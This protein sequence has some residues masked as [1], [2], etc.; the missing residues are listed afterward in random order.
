MGAELLDPI[1]H[2]GL[3]H[4]SALQALEIGRGQIGM[5]GGAFDPLGQMA[6]VGSLRPGGHVPA[7]AGRNRDGSAHRSPPIRDEPEPERG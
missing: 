7:A 3:D 5:D 6:P 4:L 2:Q 1:T